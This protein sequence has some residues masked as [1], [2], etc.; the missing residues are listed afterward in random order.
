[1]ED[2]HPLNYLPCKSGYFSK[3]FFNDP[4]GEVKDYFELIEREHKFQ[5]LTDSNKPNNAF[6]KGI[7]LT[8]VTKEDDDDIIRF[9]LLRCSSNF[10]GSTDNFRKTDLEILNKVNNV[11]KELYKDSAEFN[12]VLAQIY[13]NHKNEEGKDRKA[14]IKKHS[15]KTKDMPENALM[16][17][18]T[19]YK[20]LNNFDSDNP[21]I[22]TKLRFRQKDDYNENE[23]SNKFDIVLYPNSLF[24]IPLEI[25]RIYTHEI[26][27]SSLPIEKI[28][29]RMGYVIRSSN[30]NAIYKDGQTYIERDDGKLV[31]LEEPTEEGVKRL[32]ELYRK[33]NISSEK[34][35]YNGF[36]DNFSLNRGDYMKPII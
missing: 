11:R 19:F 34:V 36:N 35:S 1:M 32:K 2:I 14:K 31:K 5:S 10:D 22:Y 12:H 28:P 26:V 25:N 13:Y 20:D 29:T 7:Y 24:I 17:F 8:H 6:R 33:E 3:D 18:C 15:D 27:P 16:A 4:Q 21:E 30:T 23:E 9:R